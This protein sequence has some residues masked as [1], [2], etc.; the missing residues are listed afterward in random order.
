MKIKSLLILFAFIFTLSFTSCVNNAPTGDLDKDIKT[1][2]D[3]LKVVK[4]EAS[5]NDYI[6]VYKQ[7]G[8]YYKNEGKAA[9]FYR[10]IYN[11]VK[12]T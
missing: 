3:K 4:D 7:F 11:A 9:D 8:E 6:I 2:V 12:R 10:N 5:V 1:L